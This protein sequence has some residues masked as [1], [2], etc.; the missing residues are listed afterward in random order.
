MFLG[1]GYSRRARMLAAA[2][3]AHR[4][5]SLRPPGPSRS[6]VLPLRA[7]ITRRLAGPAVAK[8]APMPLPSTVDAFLEV[9][10]KSGVLE[11][12]VLDPYLQQMK[13]GG[14]YTDK[15][16]TLAAALVRDGLL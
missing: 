12:E 8:G 3:Q 4:R 9:V 2:V 1:P 16:R 14:G 6:F 15:P 10:F 5:A 11:K 7:G 13:A